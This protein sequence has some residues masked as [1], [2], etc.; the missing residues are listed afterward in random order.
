MTLQ[1]VMPKKPEN[2]RKIILHCTASGKDVHQTVDS[3]RRV[4]TRPISED[5]NGWPYVGYHYVV[6][7]DGSIHFGCDENKRG[8][9]VGNY[10]HDSIGISYVGGQNVSGPKGK[11]M[12]TRTKEQKITLINIVEALLDRYPNATVHGHKEFT[13][14]KECPSFEVRLEFGQYNKGKIPDMRRSGEYSSN[15][16]F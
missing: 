3:I 12:D 1:P 9:H 2:I 16:A 14:L 10:N 15:N 11:G 7:L 8:Y 13:R 6:Y 5:G 4:H